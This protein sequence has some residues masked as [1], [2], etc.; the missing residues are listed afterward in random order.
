MSVAD[1]GRGMD[2]VRMAGWNQTPDDWAMMLKLG[3]GFA[4][5]DE[6]G[7]LQA[8][9]MVLPY[10]AHIGWIGMVLVDE[11]A[12]RQGFATRLLNNAISVLQGMGLTAMLD[13]TPAGREV[14][15][16]IG[17]RDVAPISRWRGSGAGDAPRARSD[18]L[19]VLAEDLPS[20]LALD[21]ASFGVVR[22]NLLADFTAR[23]KAVT[24]TL[25]GNGGMLWSRAGGTATQIGPVVSATAEDALALLA[26]AL[27][28]VHGPVL[29]DVPDRETRVSAFLSSRGFQI[30]R[31]F[32]R[33]ALGDA[34]I[35][36]LGS[37]MR[38]IAGPELG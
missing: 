38:A 1:I 29:I 22:K 12:R 6:T 20:G 5:D 21:A 19:Q 13:A 35:D 3:Q 10:A 15:R 7:R 8:T 9:S 11:V 23:Q 4:I 31:P 28:R 32:M 25:P 26:A 14:Y 17:F 2:L 27:D 36:G 34:P 16:R 30:E 33:M 37:G 18:A 24:L